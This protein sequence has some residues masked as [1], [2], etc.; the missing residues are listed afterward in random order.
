MG[1]FGIDRMAGLCKIVANKQPQK[2]YH[3]N[4]KLAKKKSTLI[5]IIK[6]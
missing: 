3:K 6:K 1:A 5:I 4:D 2:V